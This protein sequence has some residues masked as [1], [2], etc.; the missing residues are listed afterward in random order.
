MNRLNNYTKLVRMY[1]GTWVAA[2]QSLTLPELNEYRTVI[3]ELLAENAPAPGGATAGVP[4][5]ADIA[6]Y[7]TIVRRATHTANVALAIATWSRDATYLGHAGFVDRMQNWLLTVKLPEVDVAIRAK[8][9]VPVVVV[10]TGPKSVIPGAGALP[11]LDPA[12]IM[13]RIIAFISVGSTTRKPAIAAADIPD[14]NVNY[15]TREPHVKFDDTR[16]REIVQD[17]NTLMGSGHPELG[18]KVARL[19]AYVQ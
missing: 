13:A 14:I 19:F 12:S 9:P 7:N 16:L 1:G 18:I 15:I 3:L 10:P 8:T 6:A 5:L 4:P 17:L 2:E 11:P